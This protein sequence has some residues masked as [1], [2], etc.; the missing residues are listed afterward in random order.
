MPLL[1]ATLYIYIYVYMYLSRAWEAVRVQECV[2]VY[3]YICFVCI[4]TYCSMW[5]MAPT[6]CSALPSHAICF[7]LVYW[8][9]SSTRSLPKCFLLN[10]VCGLSST[11]LLNNSGSYAKLLP[12]FT[13]LQNAVYPNQHPR[14]KVASPTACK[15]ALI[16]FRPRMGFLFTQFP[17]A[18][19]TKA[20]R[21][22]A[23]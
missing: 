22:M 1:H 16:V 6:R 3:I 20:L 19:N 9:P 18:L 10:P 15:K 14:F 17:A 5:Y 7:M 12:M 11:D 13:T 4:Y 21:I 23:V 8:S 2:C